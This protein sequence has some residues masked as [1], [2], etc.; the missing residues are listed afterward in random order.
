MKDGVI[1]CN[2]GYFNV[3]IDIVIFEK[4]VVKKYEVR[5]NIQGYF[6]EN[7]K[8]VFVIVEGRFVNFVVVDGYLIEIMDM[9]FV[10]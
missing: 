2:S 1:L 9:L 5:K 8:E 10:I 7:G 4:K 6:F 3:E